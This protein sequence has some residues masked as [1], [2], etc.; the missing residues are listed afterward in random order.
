ML[1]SSPR[2]FFAAS[3]GKPV[4]AQLQPAFHKLRGVFVHSRFPS[5]SPSIS[6]KAYFSSSSVDTEM[7]TV[8]TSYQLSEL[9]RLMR[10]RKLDIYSQSTPSKPP[11]IAR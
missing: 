7:E 8:D 5:A 1:L 3:K 2:L 10:E 9:R 11:R 4:A 6:W